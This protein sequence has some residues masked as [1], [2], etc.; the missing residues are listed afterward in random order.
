[1]DIDSLKEQSDKL[2][3]WLNQHDDNELDYDMI[4]Q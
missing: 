1:M 3:D 4:L 2:Q